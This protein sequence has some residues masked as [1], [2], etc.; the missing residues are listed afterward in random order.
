MSDTDGK[1]LIQGQEMGAIRIRRGRQA[2]TLGYVYLFSV[3]PGSLLRADATRS[4]D[5]EY[6]PAV[7]LG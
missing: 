2:Q 3:F 6:G 7:S 4:F 1:Q 5:A